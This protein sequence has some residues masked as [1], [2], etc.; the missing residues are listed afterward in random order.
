MAWR[1]GSCRSNRRFEP[2]RLAGIPHPRETKKLFG[3]LESKNVLLNAFNSQRMH[4]AWLLTGPVGIGK[5]TLAHLF[6]RFLLNMADSTTCR[7]VDGYGGDGLVVDPDSAIS[8]QLKTLG[9]PNFL[10]LRR[11]WVA[12]LK[13]FNGTIPIDDVRKLRTFFGNTA[14][15]RGWRVVIVDSA[16]DLNIA[17]ANALLKSLEEPP[18]RCLFFLISSQPARLPATIRSRCRLLNMKPLADDDLILATRAAFEGV[19]SQ[20]PNDSELEL[21]VSLSGGSVRRALEFLNSDSM[22][23]HGDLM[24][25]TEQLPELNYVA[26]HLLAERLALKSGEAEL[27]MFI[28]LFETWLGELVRAGAIA[29]SRNMQDESQEQARIVSALG[30]LNVAQN[31]AQWTELWET[32]SRAREDMFLLNLDRKSFILNLFHKLEK[33][34]R[35]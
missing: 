19:A 21:A 12:R 34:A 32:I 8:R 35:L 17:S 20:Q 13:R 31:L 28:S 26:I 9:H 33:I 10:L 18:E 14:G 5:A 24:R 29:G 22:K 3:H 27:A 6:T 15:G 23:L 16:D 7:D 2:T 30:K 11:Q 4:H 1:V 25:F